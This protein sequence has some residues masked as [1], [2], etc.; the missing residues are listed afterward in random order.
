MSERD[1]R[2]PATNRAGRYRET[3][4]YVG[5][6]RRSIRGLSQRVGVE[7]D[8][9]SL[10]EMLALAGQLDEAIDIAVWGLRAAGYSWAEIGARTGITKQAAFK[11]WNRQPKVDGSSSG[12]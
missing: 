11:R 3:R 12:T 7:A 1:V 10:P 9:E 5:F 8:I 2:A 4:E 6:V